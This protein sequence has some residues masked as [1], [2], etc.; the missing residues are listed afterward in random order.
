MTD[1]LGGLAPVTKKGHGGQLLLLEVL[2][3]STS[4]TC[5]HHG[6]VKQH[7]FCCPK[8]GLTVYGGRPEAPRV[9]NPAALGIT[10]MLIKPLPQLC[11]ST[12]AVSSA[13]MAPPILDLSLQ[14]A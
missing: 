5:H 6:E 4:T 12:S 9:N 10:P 11:Q 8:I 14:R 1:L 13:E 2:L 7:C 3:K